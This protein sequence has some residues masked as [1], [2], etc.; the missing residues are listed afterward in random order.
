M[1]K[2]CKSLLIFFLFLLVTSV[3]MRSARAQVNGIEADIHPST[4]TANT[5]ILI[6]F[7]T[8]NAAI[9]SVEKADIFWDDVSIGLSESGTQS[10]DGSYNYHLSV[11]TEP[12]LSDVGNHTISVD[13]TVSNY[14]QVSFNFTFEITQYV[15]SP[16]YVALNASYYALL[17]NYSDLMDNY[18]SL[19]ANYSN[20]LADYN[21][22]SNVNSTLLS[23]YSSL[24]ANMNSMLADITS[25]STNYNTLLVNYNNL[26]L[27]YT[28]FLA[29]YTS[30]KG[31]YDSLTS[32]L[33]ILRIDY[34]GLASNYTGLRTN[35]ET[36]LGE[37]SATRN[38]GYVFVA[39]TIILAATTAYLYLRK[40]K[41]ATK[42][43]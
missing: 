21:A 37:L 1:K 40:P 3:S 31:D 43:R 25:L 15:P 19:S 10:A 27:L 6:R 34:D 4:G 7:L 11:P 36:S 16:E 29:N 38:V 13:S 5:D 26:Q 33:N 23:D 32:N 9:G 22:F 42:A 2:L 24:S 28:S 30:L 12:P 39:S 8:T 20:L 35:Y 14:G 18:S 41:I 17:A